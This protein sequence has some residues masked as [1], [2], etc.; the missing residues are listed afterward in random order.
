MRVG[1]FLL[2]ARFPGQ[3]DGEVLSATVE[4]AV[5]AE[6]AGFDDVWFAEHHFMSYGVC[7]SA[8]TLAAYVLG[9]TE[10]VAVGTAVSV[11]STAHPVALAEQTALLDQVSGGRFRLGVG[12]GG[13]WIDLEVFGTGLARYESGFAESLDLLLAALSR[14]RLSADGPTFAF[15]EVPMVPR[16]RS[17][18]PVVVAC[19]SAGT[20]ALAAERRLP[21]LLGMHIG[22]DAKR[23]MI[24]GYTARAGDARVEH[25]AAVMAYVADTRAEA[26]RTLRAE[27]PRWLGPGLAGYMPVDGR[28][29]TRR[30]PDAYA[31]LLCRI[32]PVGTA[33]DCV[34]TMATTLERTGIRHLILMVEGAGAP[35]R[36]QENIA[37]LG[38]EVLPHLRARAACR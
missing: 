19:T 3:S 32:H 23:E 30:D 7:P 34:E 2:A 25:V 31:D 29:A 36:T 16:P 12:R 6:R 8:T 5:A 11:L 4:A 35:R 37:R 24:A 9:R 13:P 1:V 27:L 21:M 20:V 22:D 38:A 10:R 15:R 17:R 28:A 18:P 14:P 33:E 26:Q